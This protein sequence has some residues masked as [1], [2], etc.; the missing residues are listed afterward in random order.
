MTMDLSTFYNQFRDETS[1]NIRILTEGLLALESSGPEAA[2]WR[3]Q[4]DTIF[5]AMHTIKG[6]ARLLGFEQVGRLA[7]TCEHILGA[8]REGRR[9]LD[10][11]L[12]DDLLRGADALLELTHALVEG[13]PSSVDVEALAL[14]L[15]RGNRSENTSPPEAPAEQPRSAPD[16]AGGTAAAPAEL[17]L[18]GPIAAQASQAKTLRSA[19]RQTIRVRVDRLDRLL[20][21]AGE[22]AVGRQTQS[23]QLQMLD[24]IFALVEQQERALLGLDR[25]LKQLRFS[26]FQRESLERQMNNALNA[27]DLAGKLIR[28]HVERF[29]Q[30]AAQH[31][32]LIED[33]EQEVMAARLLPISTTFGNLPRA[34]RELARETGKE[35]ELTLEGETTELDRKVIEALNDPLVHLIRN[36]VDHGIETP[37]ERE[38]LGKPRQGSIHVS[39]QSLGSYVNVII[40]DDGRGMDPKKL[41]EAAVRKNL[42]SAETAALLTDQ[43]ALDLIFMPGFSTAQMITDISGRGVGMDVVR[44]NMLELGG[45]VHVESKLNSGTTITLALP[46]T[47]V[48]TRVLLVEVGEQIFAFPASGCQ[49]SA[50]VYTERLK[51]IEGRAMFPYEGR[52]ASLL[53]LADLLD[54]AAAKPFP[55]RQRMPAVIVGGSQRPLAL[56][57]DRLI[58]EREVV[59]KPLGPLMDKQRRY[60]GAIQLGDGRLILLLNPIA[61]VQTARGMTL[62]TTNGQRDEN[63]RHSRL[64]VA[65]DSFTT[66]ELIRTILQSAGYNVTTAVDGFDALDKLRSDTY[67]LVVSDVEM[68][69]VDGFQLTSSIR[70]ELGLADLP[71]IIVTSLASEAHKRRGLEVG[72]Q[73]YI[74]KSQFN[75][76]SLLETVQQ[77]LA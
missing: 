31:S 16:P 32:Q 41:R 45:Q 58:D 6:S 49:G 35:I 73:A 53:R 42:F 63:R 68:P 33:L 71:V 28:A 72:A 18:A 26:S 39:A 3:E 36:A 48:T 24:E 25:Q 15:G 50:W 7:H 62:T 70:H 20:N 21:L 1:E 17:P 52:L 44:T 74:V 67:D 19:A 37:I 23:A 14:T 27:G 10:R 65:D 38:A 47:L 30:Q 11:A 55:S 12:A 8:V 59:V 5:R 75:Q 2:G 69:R 29:G 66:R 22:L 34:V 76:N 64:L 56:I 77:L 54:V 61:L 51:T 13:R 46:L 43:E 40:R 57:V 60:S 9:A 4:I